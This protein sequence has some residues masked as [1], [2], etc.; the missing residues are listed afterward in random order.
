MLN[1][2]RRFY[3]IWSRFEYWPWW[4]FYIPLIPFYVFFAIR[5]RSLVYFT[6]VNPG[7]E[8]GGFF[9]E[10]KDR[11]LSKI[12]QEYKPWS[13][14]FSKYKS[15][16]WEVEVRKI[17][18]SEYPMI[19][20]PNVGERGDEVRLIA[21]QLELIQHLNTVDFDFILQEYIDYQIE[22]GLL[23]QR[24]LSSKKGKIE[25]ITL[26]K[27]LN[28]EGDGLSTVGELMKKSNRSFLQIPRFR[29]EKAE[30]LSRIPALG[31]EILLEEIGN[32]CLGTEFVD[33]NENISDALCIVFDK[34]SRSFEGFH[35]GRYD[36]RVPNWEDLKQGRNIKIF[37]LNGVSSEAGHIFDQRHGVLY[38]YKEVLRLWNILAHIASENHKAGAAYASPKEL[39]KVSRKHFF[40][41]KR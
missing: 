29:E 36:L 39:L 22:L 33:A 28:V 38:A 3:V 41:E 40:G 32:H 30:L 25:S 31:E 19:F 2:L 23:Y 13:I 8:Y 24:S 16:T 27:F 10:H 6:A 14:F 18:E 1:R 20:K 11:I 37:E 17:A 9:G 34:I 4:F 7:I 35:Y 5:T 26:K 15:E 12:P 21:A